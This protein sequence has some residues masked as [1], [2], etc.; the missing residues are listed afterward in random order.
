MS[1][2]SLTPVAL[3]FKLTQTMSQLTHTLTG[4]L[5]KRSTFKAK[6]KVGFLFL[7]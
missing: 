7:L 2:T 6:D 1:L 4:I 5:Q 3:T